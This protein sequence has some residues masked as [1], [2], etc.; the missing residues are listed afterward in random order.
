MAENVT[1]MR[2]LR[3]RL[4]AVGKTG[5]ELLED[6]PIRTVRN[7]HKRHEPHKKTGTT[8]RSVQPGPRSRDSASVEAGGAAVFLEYG[9]RP[10]DILPRRGTV[11]AWAPD[12]ANRRLSGATRKGTP[13]SALVFARRVRHPG[14]KPDP[15]MV[16]AGED[17]LAEIMH[18]HPVERNWNKAG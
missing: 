16:P 11:L 2:G 14:T 3:R 15:F 7:A 4:K 13:S 10:H 5:E 18:T 6:W 8:Y 9:T 17:A 12:A 1:G